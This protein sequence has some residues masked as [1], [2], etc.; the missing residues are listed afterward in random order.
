MSN[1]LSLSLFVEQAASMVDHSAFEYFWRGH[2]D[3]RFKMVPG[4]YRRKVALSDKEHL[5]IKE[6]ILRHPDVFSE[7][8]SF[9]E[10]LSVLQHYEFPTR[11]LDI[12]ENPLV[13]LYFACN[14]NNGK[15][16]C[17]TCFKVP[18]DKVKYFDSDTVTL[19]SALSNIPTPR[20]NGFNEELAALFN[21]DTSSGLDVLRERI[22]T[23]SR[24]SV[25][26]TVTNFLSRNVKDDGLRQQIVRIFNES[27]LLQSLLY[28]I[29]SE[30]PHF[31][32]ILDPRHFNNT[33]VC[34]KARYDGARITAQQGLFLLFGIKDGDKSKPSDFNENEIA[35]RDIVVPSGSKKSLL[36]SL[37]GFGISDERMFPEMVSSARV[38][39]GKLKI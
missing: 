9:F 31:K 38:I 1:P 32:P 4:I 29:R 15:E 34:V 27:A 30:K 21:N 16:G 33:M 14:G 19:L 13:A 12:T 18:K 11:L 17:V 7:R 3:Q 6:A 35:C 25:I 23:N 8:R 10:R 39:K 5:I 28:E 22:R 24:Q 20:F 37:G 2:S 36:K 26:T